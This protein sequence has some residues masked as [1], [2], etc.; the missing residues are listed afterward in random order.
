MNEIGLI[1]LGVMGK[2][3]VQNF[4][5]KDFT[6]SLWDRS[7]EV[8]KDFDFKYK[9]KNA[10]IY[11]DIKSFILSLKQPRKVF[12]IIKDGAPID[13]MINKILPFLDKDDCIIDLGN[14]HYKDTERRQEFLKKYHIHFIGCGI[15]GGEKGAR[16]GA[17]FMPGGEEKPTK[18][19]IKTLSKVAAK[20]FSGKPCVT[21]VGNGGSGHFVKMVHN[22]IEYAIIQVLSEIY[23]T[24]KK[25]YKLSNPK[26]SNFFE[27]LSNP[28][29]QGYLLDTVINVVKKKDTLS[30]DYLVN[31]IS[32]KAGQKGTGKW[33]C[34]DALERN[35]PVP[36]IYEALSVRSISSDF[37]LRKNLSKKYKNLYMKSK[38]IFPLSGFKYEAQ[39]SLPLIFLSIFSQGIYMIDT[40]NKQENW[41][42]KKEE[43]A[44]IWQGGCIIR[45]GVLKDIEKEF[46]KNKNISH[47]FESKIFMDY[48]NEHYH[49]LSGFSHLYIDLYNPVISSTL[50][51]INYIKEIN[52]P[53]NLIQGMRD[54]FGSHGYERTDKKGTFHTNW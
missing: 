10:Y 38:R 49:N 5:D 17:S 11:K 16:Y 20:D 8:S 37:D 3:L 34:I 7:Y 14:S 19:I 31:K 21:F 32:D 47:I 24:L 15:S 53:T 30:K 40:T 4:N 43:I 23:D 42:I 48:V 12:M 2:A 35:I 28:W 9:L 26:I 27:G 33:I 52:L 18:E 50:G 6:I 22:G 54:Y 25:K 51:Y 13:E 44:R 46:K 29:I 39:E 45:C 36:S 41:G 1:G